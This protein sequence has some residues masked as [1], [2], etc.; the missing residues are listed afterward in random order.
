MIQQ[1]AT[2]LLASTLSLLDVIIAA[3]QAVKQKSQ[4]GGRKL[5]HVN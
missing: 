1:Q 5:G 4:F 3:C 2:V